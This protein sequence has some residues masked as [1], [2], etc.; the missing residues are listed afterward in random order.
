MKNVYHGLKELLMDNFKAFNLV[1]YAVLFSFFF[2]SGK[3]M[4]AREV[5]A[6]P[7]KSVADS[8]FNEDGFLKVDGS[9]RLIIGL[10][11]LPA[12]DDKLIEFDDIREIISIFP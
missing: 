4:Q 5:S 2:A 10:Y 1:F 6:N 7:I 11:E 3:D 12:D 9:P 8:R